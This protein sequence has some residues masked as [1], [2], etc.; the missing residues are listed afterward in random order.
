MKKMVSECISHISITSEYIRKLFSIVLLILLLFNSIQTIQA[1]EN[2]DPK[3]VLIL[4]S[5]PFGMPW[6]DEIS[7][8]IYNT[9]RADPDIKTKIHAEYPGISQTYDDDYVGCLIELYRHKY[10]DTSIDLIFAVDTAASIFLL[11]YED[12]LFPD[13]PIV[14]I[15]NRTI[16]VQSRMKP[17]WTGIFP[18]KRIKETIDTAV[19]LQPKTKN[20]AV[21]SGSSETDHLIEKEARQ[22]FMEYDNYFNF[23]YLT[24]LPM[25][26]ILEEVAVLPE[27][28]I[29]LYL[30]TLVDS[31]GKAFV[32]KEIL[33]DITAASNAPVYAL[34]ESLIGSGVIGGYM[35][36]TEVEGEML[37]DIGLRILKGENIKNIPVEKALNA[38]LFDWSQM[39][40]WNIDERELPPGSIILNREYT[41][42][43]FYK[44]HLIGAVSIILLE[45]FL[46][47]LLLAQQSK[48]KSIRKTLTKSQE[49]LENKVKKRTNDLTAI[50]HK[51]EH[52][53]VNHKESKEHIQ[54]LLEEKDIILKEVHHRI[55]N[56]MTTMMSLLSLQSMDMENTEAVSALE[57]ARN[58]IQSM[59]VLYDKLYRGSDFQ[60]ISIEDYFIT[61]INE[62]TGNFD[63][64]GK[65]QIETDI[66]NFVLDSK[67][68]FSLGIILNELITNIMKYAF[69]GNKDGRITVSASIAD[70]HVLMV[71]QD[72]GIGLPESVDIESSEGF[73]LRLVKMLTEQLDGRIRIERG[74]GTKFI[75]KFDKT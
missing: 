35:I 60:N 18:E 40:R 25:E 32:P 61:L 22:I 16:A 11:T 21:I 50:N 70:E 66:E 19:R 53:I 69:P 51:L 75:L 13:I 56:N 1:T 43:D 42:W 46:I 20:V 4:F 17:N 14:T 58:R 26:Q 7:R 15:S 65:V 34:W 36:S 45:A 48:L 62:I 68:V 30:L 55:K 57:N 39:E 24:N 3:Q 44:L 54:F 72:N 41:F 49:E 63:N 38:Y 73:G 27:H 59:M 12:T 47:I 29:V 33:K 37:T 8:V 31:V 52:E 71:I 28:T 23:I 74:S 9:F 64:S 6:Q 5:H 67:T 10:K 2:E